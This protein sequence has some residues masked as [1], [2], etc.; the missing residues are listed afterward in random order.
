MPLVIRLKGDLSL[1]ALMNSLNAIVRHQ[2]VLR[3]HFKVHQ[4]KPFQVIEDAVIDLPQDDLSSLAAEDLDRE[5]RA[6]VDAEAS[7]RFDLSTGPLLHSRLL[8]LSD[9]EHVLLLTMH[10][11]ISD[12]WSLGVLFRELGN[13]YTAFNMGEQPEFAE[14]PIQYADF[15]AWQRQW[16]SGEVLATQQAYWQQKLADL[17]TLNLPTDRPRPT[18][19]TYAGAYESMKLDA[20]LSRQLEVLSKREGV[21]LFMTLLAGFA[22]L[23]HR[24]SGQDDVAIGSPI[25]NRNRSELEGLIGFFINM[26]VMRLDLSGTPG[27]RELLSQVQETAMGAYKHQD[28]PFEKLVELIQV[29][30]DRSRNP[31]F[32]VQFALQNAPIEPL[33]LEGLT[34]EPSSTEIRATRFDLEC[35]IW[36]RGEELDVV[37]IYNTDLFDADTVQGMLRH[38]RN[39]LRALVTEPERPIALAPMLDVDEKY[40]LLEQWNQASVDYRR[41]ITLNRLFEA[42]VECR[43]DALALEFDGEALSYCE[44]NTRANRLAHY[45]QANGVG[46][47]VMVGLCMERSLDLIVAILGILK[48]GGA[49]VPLDPKYPRQRLGFILEDCAAPILVT[50]SSLQAVL[51]DYRGKLVSLDADWPAIEKQDSLAPTSEAGA[52][53]SAYVIYTSGSTGQPKGVVVTHDNITRLFAATEQWYGFNERDVWTLFHSSAFDFSVWEIWGALLHGGRLV[54]VPYEISRSPDLFHEMLADAGVTVLNQ[55]PSAFR[56]LIVADEDKATASLSALRLVIFGGEALDPQSLGPW[57][58]K[59]GES[60]PQL[61]NMYGITETTVHV[62]YRPLTSSVVANSASV[63][64]RAIPDLQIYILDRHLQPVP[65]GVPG[66]MYVGGAGLARGYLNR[67]ELTAER[68]I[69]HPFSDQSGAR[70]YK[71]GDLARYLADGDIEY[72][73]RTDYQVKLR[74]F[75]IEL[76]EIESLLCQHSAVR[77]AVV[78]CRNDAAQGQRLVAYVIPKGSEDIEVADLRVHVRQ[79]LPEYMVPSAFLVLESF[80]LT[81]NGKLD[82]RAL[83]EPESERQSGE[84]FVEARTD[85]ERQLVA[86]WREVLGVSQIGIHDNFFVLGGHSLMATQ[87]RYRVLEQMNIDLKLSDLF[88][89]PTVVELSQ[90]LEMINWAN[91]AKNEEESSDREVFR[92]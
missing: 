51:P 91:E 33:Q 84:V 24:Y 15:A 49:Y 22:V 85:L 35:N 34:L 62:S 46:P 70:L 60:Q 9:R 57:F 23:M 63:I 39:L 19:Q 88:D 37:F 4:G 10:H 45:L 80:P 3:T 73:G 92:I 77:E 58:E 5:I 72:L 25:A 13:C 66:E 52:G 40:L 11:I 53:N 90:K 55:T 50:Q 2:E 75:R 82:R 31:L 26:L 29:D 38:Y 21:T 47:E 17:E 32:Q 43:P 8:R 64:G 27:F 76:G 68:F 1:V 78:L 59:H 7:R 86:I 71:T 16:L 61:V 14:L 30:R 87:V 44:L 6:Q 69:A 42:Q 12:G 81:P 56:Q 67:P 20:G 74:G 48:A 28:I 18:I 79:Q 83:P 36:T 89:Y 41:D 54:V 65:V